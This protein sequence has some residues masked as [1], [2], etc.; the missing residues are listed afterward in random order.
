[1]R[2]KC[3]HIRKPPLSSARN[4]KRLKFLSFKITKYPNLNPFILF[5]SGAGGA[6]GLPHP[7]RK[8][9]GPKPVEIRFG[10]A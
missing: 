3:T 2:E 1:M 4:Y 9:V 6:G 5:A 10:E 7:Y 8:G